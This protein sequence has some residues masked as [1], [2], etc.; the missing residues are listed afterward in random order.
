MEWKEKVK[1][2]S[3]DR[4]SKAPEA[5]NYLFISLLVRGILRGTKRRRRGRDRIV[6]KRQESSLWVNNRTTGSN[7]GFIMR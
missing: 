6:E 7:L 4:L 1:G 3:G 5:F 2:G